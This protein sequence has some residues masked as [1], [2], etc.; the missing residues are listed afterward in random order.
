MNWD[1]PRSFERQR[2]LLTRRQLFGLGASG[3]GL[4]ALS[5]LLGSETLATPNLPLELQRDS[6]IKNLG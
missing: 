5:S 2:T 3:L 4:A 6:L 1:L